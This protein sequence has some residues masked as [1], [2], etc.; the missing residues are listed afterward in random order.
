METKILKLRN[1]EEIVGNVSSGDGE[2][3]KIQNPLKVNIYPRIKKGKV[4]E[5]MAFSRWINYSQN[6]TYDIIKNNVI[7]ITDS[8]VGL[9]RFYDFCVSKMEDMKTTEYR[10]PSDKELQNIESE[11]RELMS[12]WYDEDDDEKPTIH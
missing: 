10:Q 5:A 12:S 2:F 9:T 3:L 1:G 6:Q 4:E 8:S 7:A 11:V